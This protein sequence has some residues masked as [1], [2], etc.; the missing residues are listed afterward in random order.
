MKK[1]VYLT[2]KDI[3]INIMD[4]EY[5]IKKES[6]FVN[7]LGFDSINLLYLQVA[8]EDEFDIKF[9]PVQDDFS[10]IFKDIKSLC[11]Y[12]ENNWEIKSEE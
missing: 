3:V 7:D 10:E 1:D 6:L 8:V 4:E 12:V 2:I 11:D 5:E 9:D